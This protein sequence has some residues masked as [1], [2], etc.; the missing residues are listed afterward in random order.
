MIKNKC[1]RYG[2][3]KFDLVVLTETKWKEH[4]MEEVGKFL[5]IYGWVSK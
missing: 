1:K 3:L 2:K 4:A 5:H